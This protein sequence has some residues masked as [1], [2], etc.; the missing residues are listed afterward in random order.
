MQQNRIYCYVLRVGHWEFAQEKL[1]LQ[2]TCAVMHAI[3][4]NIATRTL[5]RSLAEELTY[6][7]PVSQGKLMLHS[8]VCTVARRADVA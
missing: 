6:C 3:S 8:T 2:M 5:Q 1:L 7:C 4:F